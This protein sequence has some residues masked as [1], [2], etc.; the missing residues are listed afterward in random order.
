[1]IRREKLLV[2]I[3]LTALNGVLLL[4]AAVGWYAWREAV[5]AEEQH[6]GHLAQRLGENVEQ[7]IIDARDM[8]DELNR[9]D[10]KP[11]SVAHMAAMQRAVI[12]Q[13]HTRAIGYWQAADR[14]CGVGLVQGAELTPS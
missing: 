14:L 4:F 8:L 12:S 11:C 7:T 10:V 1:M 13:P 6:L 3:S 9:L 2:G 5:V